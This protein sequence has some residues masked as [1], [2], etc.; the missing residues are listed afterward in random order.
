MQPVLFN[1][2]DAGDFPGELDKL[3]HILAPDG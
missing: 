2:N 1:K 3:Y